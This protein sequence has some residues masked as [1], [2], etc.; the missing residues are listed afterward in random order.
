MTIIKKCIG[1]ET[2]KIRFNTSDSK[3][4][5]RHFPCRWVT[6]LPEHRNII[7]IPL[8]IFDK[9]SRLDKHTTGATSR[10]INSTMI[11]L[12][13]LNQCTD[14][15]CRRIEFP[16]KFTFSLSKFR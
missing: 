12:K 2:T 5:I 3:I 8:V 7:D 11:R 15:T 10:V 4:H 14:Y 6:I 9:F 1:C 13:N 16:G